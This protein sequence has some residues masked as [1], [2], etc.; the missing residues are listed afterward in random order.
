[1]LFAVIVIISVAPLPAISAPLSLE[2]SLGFN[3]RFQLHTWTPVTV[4]IENRGRAT[5]GTLDIMLTSGSEYHQNV[6]QTT[7][8]MDVDLPH[9][10]RKRYA[11]TVLIKS[12]THEMIIRLKQNEN[13]LISQSVNLRP[14]FSEKSF[15]V[16][17]DEFVS[18]DIL[19]VLPKTIDPVN[20]PPKFLPETWYG[21]DS[22]KLLVMKTDSIRRLRERQF[23]A[24]TQ[25][26]KQGG[27]LIT[28]GSLN[29]GSLSDKRI[30]GILPVRVLGQQR[31]FELTSLEN[32]CGRS[33]RSFESF[34]VLNVRMENSDV[35][36]TEADIPIIIQKH[37]GVGQIVFLAFDYNTQPFSNWDGRELF[38]EKALSMR[39]GID[40]QGI[41]VDHNKI[42]DSMLAKVPANFPNSKSVFIL[43]GAYLGLLWFLMKKLR[44]SVERRWH[45][46]CFILMIVFTFTLIS[47]WRFFHPNNIKGFTYNS[48]C[49]LDVS[50]PSNVAS[51]K[52]IIGLYALKKSAYRLGFES[53][54]N[55][56]THILAKRSKK[57]TPAPYV[58]HENHIG[59]QI[60]SILNKWDHSL[61][62]VTSKIKSPV[63]GQAV[64]D[65]QHLTLTIENTLPHRIVDCMIYYKKRFVFIDDIRAN[66][67][68]HIKLKL[69]NLRKTEIFYEQQ[70]E[71]IINRLN[72]HAAPSYLKTSQR[73]LTE[74]VIR[75]IHAKFSSKRDS[76]VLI[77]WVQGGVMQPEFDQTHPRSENLTLINWEIP[78]E[79]AS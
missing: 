78:V 35:L 19:A 52:Y 69:S 25:W 27:Y 53:F 74:D 64:R 72:V 73:K 40:T 8:A 42:L 55:S 23:Q 22:V 65:N 12:F 13:I 41:L 67:R 37:L 33:L 59:Q 1:M 43:I 11:F 28:A 44:T 6:F 51:A 10:S 17:A 66:K 75:G 56:I 34:L 77:G 61:Y 32:F 49:Q 58:I 31:L 50:G 68:Q 18:P 39:S 70:A 57:K 7:Y 46:S 9:N 16:V 38:W 54:S 20:V 71:Q 48:F 5:R 30:Q 14:H 79:I 24:L 26:I 29:Y 62:M 76:V 15:A 63:V 3:G 45:N 2:Y 21:Y 47:Y 36:I 60:I 4:V